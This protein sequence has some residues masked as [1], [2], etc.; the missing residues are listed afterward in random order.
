MS[1][2]VLVCLILRPTRQGVVVTLHWAASV[3]LMQESV[4][5]SLRVYNTLS[6]RFQHY[7]S[8]SDILSVCPTLSQCV[9][10]SLSVSNSSPSPTRQGT[11]VALH[12][13]AS[14]DLMQE[15]IDASL[16]SN[17]VRHADSV[18]HTETRVL[19]TLRQCQT[20]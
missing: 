18:S 6:Q 7:F 8:V 3:D 9:F 1:K 5:A 14:V 4:D 11:V 19:D 15:S 2:T 12:W 20:H 17:F 13:A 10:H 16:S